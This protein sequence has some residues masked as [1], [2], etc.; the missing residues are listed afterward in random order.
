MYIERAIMFI[1]DRS[2]IRGG[3]GLVHFHFGLP[4][5][6]RPSPFQVQKKC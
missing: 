2:K 1:R 3:G 4:V 5:L 6:G